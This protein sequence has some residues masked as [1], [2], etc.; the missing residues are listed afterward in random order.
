MKPL[1]GIEDS[2]TGHQSICPPASPISRLFSFLLKSVC[3]LSSPVDSAHIFEPSLFSLGCLG[4]VVWAGR[5]ICIAFRIL[6]QLEPLI[7]MH[8]LCHLVLLACSQRF[9]LI[10]VFDIPM[11]IPSFRTFWPHLHLLVAENDSLTRWILDNFTRA[12]LDPK[13]NLMGNRFADES[14]QKYLEFGW[15]YPWGVGSH[16]VLCHM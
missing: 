5:R 6:L 2:E 1:V 15:R 10:L 7:M 16:T 8:S 14:A 4:L 9:V 13:R 11:S 12:K 3:A